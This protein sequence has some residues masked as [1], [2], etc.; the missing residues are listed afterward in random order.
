VATLDSTYQF[1][2]GLNFQ[3]EDGTNTWVLGCQT[4]PVGSWTKISGEVTVPSG[5]TKARVWTQINATSNFGNWYMTKI[6]VLRKAN[7]ELIVDGAVTASKIAA[8]AITTGS[9]IIADGAITTA[10]IANAAITSAQIANLAVGT[11]AIQDGAITNAKIT[12]AAIGTAAIQDGAITNAKITNLAVSTSQIQDAAITSAKIASLAVGNAAIQNGSITNA[13]I[14]N[15][16]VGTAQIQDAAITNAKIANLAVDDAKIANLNGAKITAGTI[17]SDKIA[18]NSITANHIQSLNGLNVNNQFIVDGNGNVTFKGSLQGASGTFNGTLSVLYSDSFYNS[19]T[20]I[21]SSIYNEGKAKNYDYTNYVLVQNGILTVGQNQ[22]S[23]GNQLSRIDVRSDQI[24]LYG[25]QTVF[26]SNFLGALDV[27]GSLIVEN[28]LTVDGTIFVES[29][30]D[31][32]LINGWSNYGGSYQTVQFMKDKFGFVHIRGS[33]KG[34][35]NNITAFILPPGYRPSKDLWF[36]V[37]AGVKQVAN[38]AIH[39]DGRVAIDTQ[40]LSYVSLDDIPP[41]KA[42]Q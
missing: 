9:A 19:K 20:Q 12:N 34:T 39:P 8:G 2:V 31:A 3:K 7:T 6:T 33:L 32:S 38:V 27:N 26:L 10:K 30:Q 16:A 28:N 17:T 41:F 40:A 1:G 29:Y 18:A 24:V 14:A 21:D 13:K 25:S 37:S 11:A 23:T 36:T 5:F 35:T 42:E 22:T 15:L 4:T